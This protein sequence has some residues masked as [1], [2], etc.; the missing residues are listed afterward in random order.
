VIFSR[1]FFGLYLLAFVFPVRFADSATVTTLSAT[2]FSSGSSTLN[3]AATLSAGAANFGCFKYGL[4]THYGSE[5]AQQLL[6]SSGGDVNF[7]QPLTGLAHNQIYHFCA[8]LIALNTGTI[9]GNDLTFTVPAAT[10]RNFG[11]DVSHFQEFNGISKTNWRRCL[12]WQT[13]L[14]L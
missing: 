9:Y 5:T 4:T 7:N 3:A 14:R 10:N 13:A 11:A 12:L 6:A 8:D 1:S 2:G